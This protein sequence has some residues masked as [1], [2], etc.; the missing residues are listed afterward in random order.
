V[1]ASSRPTLGYVISRYPKISHTFVQREILGLRRAG[2][3]V[4]SF[5]VVQSESAEILSPTDRDEAGRTVAIRPAGVAKLWR[6]LLRPMMANPAAAFASFKVAGRHWWG[7]PRQ[8]VWRIFYLV[9]AIMLWSLARELGVTHLHAHHANVASDVSRLAA[10]FGTRVGSGPDSWT[11]TM[12]GSSEFIDIERHDLGAKAESA[13]AVACVS[14]FTRSQLMMVTESRHWSNYRIVHCGVDP[15]TYRPDP[16]DRTDNRFTVLF[17]GRLGSEKGLPVLVEALGRLQES[18]APM[19]VHFLVVGDGELRDEIEQRCAA[20]GVDT[21]FTGS[22]GQHEILPYYHRADA[23]AMASFREGIPVVLM[24][25]MACEVPCVAPRITAIPE[26]IEEGVTGLTATA[27]RADHLA[28][29][30]ERYALDPDFARGVGKAGR[31][32]ILDEFTT[33][34]TVAAMVEFFDNLNDLGSGPVRP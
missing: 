24:E 16:E 12:H 22:V 29:Q 19:Q 4:E 32:K 18:V 17:V 9:E 11:F 28:E 31:A 8:L 21:E 7:D 6:H 13:A 33:D 30:L 23:F 34:A 15:E 5:S 10:D 1:S 2:F 14:D 3:D 25:A 20:L 27:G 26:L